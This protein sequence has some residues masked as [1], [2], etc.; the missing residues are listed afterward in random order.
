MRTLIRDLLKELGEDPHREGLRRTPER[1][2]RALE[3]LTAGYRLSVKEVLNGAVFTEDYR[4]M[5][6]VKDIDL[7]SL[8]EHHLLPFFGKC[9]IAYIP[10]GK[11]AGLSKLPRLVEMFARRLQVQER[12][13]SQ[14]A[15]AIQEALTPRGVGVIVEAYH[16]CMMMRGIQKQNA[17][18]VTTCML[19]AF[20]EQ[21]D[22]RHEFLRIVQMPPAT[23]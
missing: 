11:I 4:E 8:C 13:T 20:R 21:Q 19:G 7:Y 23:D 12:L 9:H 17:R 5:V 14:I 16:L 6:V 22:V 2:E 10:D 15:E 18:V 3:F 1:V